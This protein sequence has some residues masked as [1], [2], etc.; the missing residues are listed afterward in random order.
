M[1]FNTCVALSLT[2]S[3]LFLVSSMRVCSGFR[4]SVA[5]NLRCRRLKGDA[6]SIGSRF[7]NFGVARAKGQKIEDHSLLDDSVDNTDDEQVIN[8]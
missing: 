3:Q 8:L 2:N 5:C 6:V 7:R 4:S 1:A